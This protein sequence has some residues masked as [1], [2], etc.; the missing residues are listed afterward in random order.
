MNTGSKARITKRAVDDLRA[1]AKDRGRTLYLRDDEVTGFGAVCTKTGATSY[2]IEYQLGGRG[3]T[4]KRMTLG[5]HGVLTPEQARQR[6]KEE[7]GRVARHVD[8]VQV[9]KDEKAKLTGLTFKDAV[10]RFLSIH[11]KGTRYW[12][13]KQT[14]LMSADTKPIASKPMATITRVQIAATI[15]KVQARSG[16]AARHLF[17]DVRPVFAWALDRGLIE[18]NPMA[19]MK[20][21]AA[22]E[23]RDRVLTDEEV[24]AFWQAATEEGW[25]FSSVFKVLLLTGQRRE[26]VAGMRWREVTLD[27]PAQWTIAK[28][29]A[30]NG[31]AHTIDLHPEAV[32][33]LDPLGD[34]AAARRAGDAEYVFS[35]T[36]RTPVSGFG[37]VKDRIDTRMQATLGGKFQPWRIH[38]LRR[39]AASGMAALGFQPHV[40]ERVLNHVSGAQG[41]LVGVYQ[42]HE[43]KDERKRAIMAWGD[44]LMQLVS[45]EEKP[46][47]NV[48]HVDFRR[49]G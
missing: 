26:E 47:T 15:D 10:E 9:K 40:I 38:D 19:G 16:A 36:G 24:K 30:K 13:Q 20:A 21:P 48:K 27:D 18:T 12:A 11:G 23:A 42:R 44:Y 45:C 33:L 22:S 28:E 34:A 31:K 35:T 32:R 46:A 14:R 4:Q 41:G 25:P 49:A 1:R 6:A 17:A 5:K 37:R 29:R 43:Y 8:V 39:T 2:F 7:L 3:T